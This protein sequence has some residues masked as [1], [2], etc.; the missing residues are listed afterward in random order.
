[1][2]YIR[3]EYSNHTYKITEANK[4]YDVFVS[5]FDMENKTE[6]TEY[7]LGDFETMPE[8]EKAISRRE[9]MISGGDTVML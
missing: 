1:M 8:V 2:Q 3:G 6:P 9:M 5:Y 7:F 4:A